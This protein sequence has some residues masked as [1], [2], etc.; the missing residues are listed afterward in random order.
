MSFILS[1]V[2]C[3][4]AVLATVLCIIPRL[5]CLYLPWITFPVLNGRAVA[6]ISV[7]SVYVSLFPEGRLLGVHVSGITLTIQFPDTT[8]SLRARPIARARGNNIGLNQTGQSR[9]FEFWL[10]MLPLLGIYVRDLTLKVRK[11]DLSL[12]IVETSLTLR[13]SHDRL[14]HS[15]QF[16]LQTG[17]ISADVISAGDRHPLLTIDSSQLVILTKHLEAS[18]CQINLT[19]GD[20]A[21]DVSQ[22][23]VLCMG[24]LADAVSP[25]P[26]SGQ[27]RRAPLSEEKVDDVVVW[28][29]FPESIAV[30][31]SSLQL[32]FSRCLPES[33]SSKCLS[34]N[35]ESS[36]FI[37]ARAFTSEMRAS[38][39]TLDAFIVD[40]GCFFVDS[41]K[42][43]PLTTLRKLS[44]R[45]LLI[46]KHL[47]DRPDY[48]REGERAKDSSFIKVW[49]SSPSFT[50]SPELF[51]WATFAESIRLK[52]PSSTAVR[53]QPPPKPSPFW[54][55]FN[56]YVDL[57]LSFG[58]P[59]IKFSSGSLHDALELFSE[60]FTVYSP[61]PS[62]TRTS[63]TT[64]HARVIVA[65]LSI[66]SPL[67]RAL[68][69]SEWRTAWCA[70][71]E[72]TAA[73]TVGEVVRGRE[74]DVALSVS[75]SLGS[76]GAR[77]LPRFDY[78]IETIGK[79]YRHK[80][81]E[82]ANQRRGETTQDLKRTRERS[83]TGP[84]VGRSLNVTL[85]ADVKNA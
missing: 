57:R 65:A 59:K 30:Q 53:E 35:W 69:Q 34:L 61:A 81:E 75:V 24:D 72:V 36:E 44:V 62:R 51:D 50:I 41:G 49:F 7:R 84:V 79:V 63:A 31:T 58:R 22:A 12:N 54:R 73:L 47:L 13:I 15:L 80:L 33:A 20:V 26:P 28:E 82:V 85:T 71:A 66:N 14:S 6:A 23:S 10:R 39:I 16:S 40:S 70:K 55:L 68:H 64:R 8:P 60:T 83:V 17:P 46:P 18:Q 19:L 77:I 45:S 52:R 11:A 2:F 43:T 32:S 42:T 5:L 21:V 78:L 9:A 1:V 27:S 29:K 74:K 4:F 25:R 48:L 56:F 3:I 76:V 37:I 67:A 38:I